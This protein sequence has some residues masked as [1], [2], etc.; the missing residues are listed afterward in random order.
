MDKYGKLE[1]EPDFALA[2]VGK[3]NSFEAN[4]GK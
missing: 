4:P 1:A 3:V 2:L